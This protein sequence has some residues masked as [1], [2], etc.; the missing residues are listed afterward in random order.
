MEH[1]FGQDFS[2]V[3]VH[4]DSQAA[5]SAEDVDARAY[6]V[7]SHVVFGGGHYAPH[8]RTG[9]HLLAHE[10]AHVV[11]QSGNEVRRKAR[12]FEV[13][14]VN[15]PAERE[16]DDAADRVMANVPVSSS[17]SRPVSLQRAPR[18]LP[19][20]P[21]R[22]APAIVG[23]DNDGP[24][25]TEHGPAM[26]DQGPGADLTG[27][28][29]T[30][31]WQCMRR[32]AGI[33]NAC[34]KATL[35]WSDFS[36][37]R[38]LPNHMQAQTGWTVEVKNMEPKA[39]RC[40]QQ[41]LGW[42]ANQTHIYQAVFV[43]RDSHVVSRVAHAN[44][45]A[46]NGCAKIGRDCRA[47]FRSTPNAL[48]YT[49]TPDN[50]SCPA[51]QVGGVL[52]ATKAS[53]CNA[54]VRGCTAMA[55]NDK[56]RLLRHEQGHLDLVC[57]MVRKINAAVVSGQPWASF[58]KNAFDAVQKIQDDYDDTTH[59]C[60]PQHQKDWETKISKGLPDEALPEQTTPPPPP[61]PRR[62]RPPRPSTSRTLP[63]TRPPGTRMRI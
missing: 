23:M 17:S 4:A 25:K 41:I 15:D 63:Q 3:R 11:Q 34:P 57:A 55:V 52:E 8:T 42:S 45:P 10:L 28:L 9:L 49:F 7:G 62:P 51:M 43:K 26:D 19:H 13:G 6:T 12:G 1:G 56:P 47:Y 29:E 20:Q 36:E 22:R 30:R 2:R 58:Q 5:R 50:S 27:K 61:P 39:A 35:T 46:R 32:T 54:M 18:E 24:G 21:P 59:G 37:V 16:A 40:V 60:D 53:E 31:L 48:P 33:P 44:D 14:A 38:S